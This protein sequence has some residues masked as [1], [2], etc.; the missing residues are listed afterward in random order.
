[1]TYSEQE[2]YS[3]KKKNMIILFNLYKEDIIAN[4]DKIN[5]LGLDKT[6][7][8]H[9]VWMCETAV[10]CYDEFYISDN[11]NSKVNRWL[12]FIQG[13]LIATG[14]TTVDKERD[15]TRYLLTEHKKLL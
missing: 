13:I 14:C 2:I 6:N 8:E 5:K 3:L 12:G 11:N 4:A 9:L 10:K 7:S 15:R 1:M